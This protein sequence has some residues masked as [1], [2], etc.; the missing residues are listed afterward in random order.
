M[1][2]AHDGIMSGHLGASKTKDRISQHFYWQN[3]FADI[4]RYCK[5]CD[6]CQRTLPKGCVGKVILG[7]APIIGTVF[8]RVALDLIGPLPVTTQ[9]HR[10]ILTL[11]D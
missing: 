8:S 10:Y 1:K 4:D 11:V 2:L 6:I 3:M 7:S 5:S 9:E